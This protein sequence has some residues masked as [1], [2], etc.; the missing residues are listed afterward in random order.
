[1]LTK[2]PCCNKQRKVQE[3]RRLTQYCE[4]RSEDNWITCC[5]DCKAADDEHW[6]GMWEDYYQSQG[7][8]GFW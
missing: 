3:Y 6:K 7:V 1:M 4:E 8:G 5:K 2:C